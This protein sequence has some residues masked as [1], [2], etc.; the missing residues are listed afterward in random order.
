MPWNVELNIN[1]KIIEL[2]YAGIVTPKALEEAFCAAV[3]LATENDVSLFLADCSDMIGGHSVADL[4][5][6][7][8]IFEASGFHPRSREAIVLP[9]L[10]T[11]QQDVAFYETACLNRGYEVKIFPNRDEALN[12]LTKSAVR[13]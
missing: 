1:Q 3:K 5:F 9:A 7:I 11:S 2:T 6:L 12:W 8:S 4:Y 13:I 10:D